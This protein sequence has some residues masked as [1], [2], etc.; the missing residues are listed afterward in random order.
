MLDQQYLIVWTRR[1]IDIHRYVKSK[2]K[3]IGVETK[4]KHEIDTVCIFMSKIYQVQTSQFHEKP[5]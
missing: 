5:L 3:T 2:N 1:V 4:E